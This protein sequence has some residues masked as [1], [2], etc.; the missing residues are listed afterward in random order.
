MIEMT[1][2]V[3]MQ[4]ACSKDEIEL[5]KKAE[6]KRLELEERGWV[7]AERASDDRREPRG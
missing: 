7:L 5:L 2:W 1:T 6:A 3:L 4:A